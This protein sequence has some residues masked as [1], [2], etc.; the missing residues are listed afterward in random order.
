[1]TETESKRLTPVK[2]GN[3]MTSIGGASGYSFV[4]GVVAEV[5]TNVGYAGYV[6][7]YHKTKSMY[8]ERG[9]KAYINYI[10][11]VFS[12]ALENYFRE[13]TGI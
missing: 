7:K 6:H 13:I 4:R 1:M 9:Y 2:T 10:E 5:G 11:K 12:Q 8:M 3:L